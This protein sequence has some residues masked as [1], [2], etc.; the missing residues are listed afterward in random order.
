M[1]N[2][3]VSQVAVGV[4]SDYTWVY[5]GETRWWRIDQSHM[6]FQEASSKSPQFDGA[7]SDF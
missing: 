6:H 3:F 1:W 2:G 7:L 4:A 5:D